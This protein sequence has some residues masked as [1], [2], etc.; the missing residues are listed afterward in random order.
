MAPG[1]VWSGCSALGCDDSNVAGGKNGPKTPGKDA[2]LRACAYVRALLYVD[3]SVCLH[4]KREHG[5]RE[6]GVSQIQ[7]NKSQATLSGVSASLWPWSVLADDGVWWLCIVW[8]ITSCRRHQTAIN[9]AD[10]AFHLSKSGW[11]YWLTMM[12]ESWTQY[13]GIGIRKL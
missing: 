4:W 1:G 13:F 3:Y 2:L 6:W 11:L 7:T 12:V 5:S 8:Q 9:A 10:R